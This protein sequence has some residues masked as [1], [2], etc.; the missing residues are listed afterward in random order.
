MVNR[1]DLSVEEIRKQL[2]PYF[3]ERCVEKA[4]V[5]G[6]FARGTATRRSDIDVIIVMDTDKRFFERYDEF[7]DIGNCIEG[8]HIDILIYTPAEIESISDRHF[9]RGALKEG[10]VIY[11]N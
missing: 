2:E 8:L 7:S 6:S 4:I 10:I 1:A 3:D 9:I 11:G 5:F